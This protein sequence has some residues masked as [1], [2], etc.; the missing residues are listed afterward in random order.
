MSLE[1]AK[2]ISQLI[3]SDSIDEIKRQLGPYSLE[4][5]KYIMSTD[6]SGSSILFYAVLHRSCLVVEYFIDKCGAN[7]NS[8]G[9]EELEKYNLSVESSLF[10]PQGNARDSLKTRC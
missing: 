2:R 4:Q 5:R 7:P 9:L 8:L 1:I 3:L 10:K 6:I